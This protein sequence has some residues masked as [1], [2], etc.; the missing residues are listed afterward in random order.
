MNKSLNN[1]S[2]DYLM[3]INS[4]ILKEKLNKDNINANNI[5]INIIENKDKEAFQKIMFNKFNKIVVFK[6]KAYSLIIVLSIALIIIYSTYKINSS[7]IFKYIFTDF[8]T[9][10]STITNRYNMLYYY[11]NIFRT[12]ILFPISDKK[13]KLENVMEQMEIYYTEENNKFLKIIS[14]NKKNYYE[15]KLL[16][17]LLTNGMNNSTEKIKKE[18]CIDNSDCINYLDSIYNIFDSG[19]DF[20][21]KMSISS[22]NNIY[23][24]YKK[25]IN[26]TDIKKIN[27][28]LM[29][30]DFMNIDYSLSSI[31]FIIQERVY[32]TFDNDRIKYI[33]VYL[34]RVIALNIISIIISIISFIILF[35]VFNS[36]H[37]YI[38]PIKNS[39]HRINA[40]IYYIKR[41]T[42]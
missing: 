34:Q 13:Q 12:L 23:M 25:I 7:L 28:T 9:D 1:T 21:F 24:D 16:F 32:D 39:I 6:I 11:F 14:L 27:S 2:L 22:I 8:F 5:K 33:E 31:F 18:I 3:D 29:K 40:S 17:D 15:T 20:A 41:Y 26:K 36:I 42:L 35:L 4:N 19:V 37:N 10:F 38:K 30:L